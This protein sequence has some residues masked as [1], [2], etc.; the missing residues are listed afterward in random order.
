MTK[1]DDKISKHSQEK[2]ENINK[3]ILNIKSKLVILKL[4]SVKT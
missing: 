2:W 3:F 1:L 4:P